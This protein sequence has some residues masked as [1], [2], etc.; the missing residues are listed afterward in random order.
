MNFKQHLQLLK[1][2]TTRHVAGNVGYCRKLQLS[3]IR[4]L[5]PPHGYSLNR[6]YTKSTGSINI[7]HSA[8]GSPNCAHSNVVNWAATN[9]IVTANLKKVCLPTKTLISWKHTKVAVHCTLDTVHCTLDTIHSTNMATVHNRLSVTEELS[10]HAFCK[11]V[12]PV[13]PRRRVPGITRPIRHSLPSYTYIHIHIYTHTPSISTPSLTQHLDAHSIF[14][15][16]YLICFTPI[17]F[18]LQPNTPI[19]TPTNL[20]R[21]TTAKHFTNKF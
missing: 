16:L 13:S 15:I 17:N 3:A 20:T 1:T 10:S 19:F 2:K 11:I 8:S 4:H 21:S 7:S 14:Y 6:S 9:S 5:R 18:N 12:A